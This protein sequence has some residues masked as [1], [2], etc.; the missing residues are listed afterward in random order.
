MGRCGTHDQPA[1][2]YTVESECDQNVLPK[3]GKNKLIHCAILVDEWIRN[4]Y[5][6]QPLVRYGHSMGAFVVL[7]LNLC[8]DDIDGVILTGLL[9]QN[10]W[11]L[12]IQHLFLRMLTLLL[13]QRKPAKLAHYLTFNPLNRRFE[14]KK[15]GFEWVSLKI[16]LCFIG[17]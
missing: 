2:G 8:S 11:A 6:D 15:S 5:K 7:N 12:I 9:Y 16:K 4:Q 13:G 17:I 14:N 3:N 1:S 10:K